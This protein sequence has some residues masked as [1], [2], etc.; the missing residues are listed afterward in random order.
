MGL[1]SCLRV[2]PLLKALPAAKTA[3]HEEVLSLIEQRSLCGKGM[4]WMDV[5]LLA[6]ALLSR[7]P[8]WTRDRNLHETAISLRVAHKH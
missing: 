8:L 7:L 1:A 6:S 2:L 3:T 5:H 4:G